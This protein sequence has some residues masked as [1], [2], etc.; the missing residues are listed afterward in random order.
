MIAV[1]LGFFKEDHLC[2][3]MQ[4]NSQSSLFFQLTNARNWWVCVLEFSPSMAQK[5]NGSL[6]IFF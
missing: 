5:I 2:L 6:W 1:L 3:M 4:Q